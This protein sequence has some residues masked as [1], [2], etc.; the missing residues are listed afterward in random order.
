[1][2]VQGYAFGLIATQILPGTVM[3]NTAAISGLSAGV[4]EIG[5][6]LTAFLNGEIATGAIQWFADGFAIAG[7]QNAT[8]TVPAS[9]EA[10][11]LTVTVAD[12]MP[13]LAAAVH[14]PQPSAA[15]GLSDVTYNQD[16]G[17]QTL[18]SAG[19]F[20]FA[21][22][23]TYSLIGPPTGAMVASDTGIVS[24]DTALLDVQSGTEMRLRASDVTNAARFTE[25]S[26]ALTLVATA[27]GAPTI[28]TT[29]DGSATL[30]P[31]GTAPALPAAP[32]IT[33]TGNG[34]VTLDA[35]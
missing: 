13:S 22:T 24:F 6:T 1:M 35:A 17:I 4:A 21:G 31:T 7:A 28:S 15:G 20:S 29:G 23:L 10:Q 34:S 25:T 2:M 5:T 19:D 9:L 8:Y 18:A 14:Y 30:T 26:F 11:D 27:W 12:S 32:T 3:T 16:T 33:S